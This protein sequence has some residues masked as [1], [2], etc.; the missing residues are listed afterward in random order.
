M[1]DYKNIKE[2]HREVFSL[3]DS[4]KVGGALNVAENMS[5][6]VKLPHHRDNVRQIR[7]TYKYMVHYLLE[8][9][10]DA[11]RDTMYADITEQI[12]TIAD[13]SLREAKALDSPDL[14]SSTLR[15]ARLKKFNL[16]GMIADFNSL[17]MEMSLAESAGSDL[18]EYRRH[19][20]TALQDIFSSLLVSYGAKDDYREVVRFL[21][22]ADADSILAAQVVSAMTLS[23]IILFDGPKLEALI[24]LY[25]HY[26]STGDEKMAAR[27]LAGVIFAIYAS[28]K[29]VMDNPAIVRQ[30]DMW[31]DSIMTYRRL[32]ETVRVIIGTRDTERVTAKMREEVMPELMKMRPDI[33]KTM[34]NL[35]ESPADLE[36]ALLEN[37]P[38]WEERLEKSG[39]TRKMQELSEMQNDG[40][41]LLMVTFSNLKQF[42]FFNVAANWFLPY[43]PDHTSINVPEE[44]REAI[45]NLLSLGGVI[46]DSD[47]Y[48]LSLALG[49]MPAAQRDMML[50]QFSA[51]FNQMSEEIKERQ[52]K[53]STPV[54]D[55][56]ILMVVRDM[57]RFFK[58]FRN[59]MQLP[60]PFE[61]PFDFQSIPVVGKMME[62]DEVLRIAAEFYFKRGYYSEALPL[63]ESVLESNPQEV[64]LLEKIGYCH[65]ILG[66]LEQAREAFM[67]AELLQNPSQ[68]LLRK[69]AF[70]NRQL[71][72][73]EEAIKYHTA[74]LE[75]E[76]DSVQLL[77]GLGT[78]LLAKGDTASALRNFYHANYVQPDAPSIMRLVART[79]LLN[80]N[81]AK[82]A[83][84]YLRIPEN[85]RT[86]R[87]WI[88]AGHAEMVQGHYR[89]AFDYYSKAFKTNANDFEKIFLSDMPQ[90]EQL[91]YD[92]KAGRIIA[93]KILYP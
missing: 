36:S 45:I 70:V 89:K 79:E 20:E 83:D 8:G 32:R 47:K 4:Y 7:E 1:S 5:L 67:K 34:Q 73:Y 15:L 64:S 54:F 46:S 55:S 85:E 52:L 28:P 12:R 27:A 60:D 14:Y 39:I 44:S 63:L 86:D 11:G 62:D 71:G 87:D 59:R 21:M 58:L 49:Q 23:L 35:S 33:M 19:R 84:Y 68:W 6:A 77:T 69:L 22:D 76:P 37:N 65:Q 82:S 56:E 61:R 2:M 66:S 42:P 81:F 10:A 93:D 9:V 80:G 51:Q 78:T 92:V 26:D 43:S 38:E 25:N 17:G 53:S 88:G 41:D 31:Q 29:R 48:S 75:K 72:N 74:A 16:P 57:Y 91:G 18:S 13:A 90:L 50:G 30:L 3:L 40:A 24:E